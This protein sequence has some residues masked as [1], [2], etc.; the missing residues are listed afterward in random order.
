ME[1]YKPLCTAHNDNW[2]LKRYVFS[3][4]E[5]V[6][7]ISGHK[8]P[9]GDDRYFRRRKDKDIGNMTDSIYLE[10]YAS[11][12]LSR[13]LKISDKARIIMSSEIASINGFVL[14]NWK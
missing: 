8:H 13:V 3:N 11:A 4:A 5:I 1:E 14:G 7:D 12:S 10:S 9:H 2:I 6:S